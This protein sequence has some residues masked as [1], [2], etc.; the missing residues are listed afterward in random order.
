MP[1][2]TRALALAPLASLDRGDLLLH[3]ISLRQKDNTCGLLQTRRGDSIYLGHLI[4]AVPDMAVPPTEGQMLHSAH[5]YAFKLDPWRALSQYAWELSEALIEYDGT[6]REEVLIQEYRLWHRYYRAVLQ[7][8]LDKVTP[9][10]PAGHIWWCGAKDPMARPFCNIA[11]YTRVPVYRVLWAAM[12]KDE[13]IPPGNMRKS[14]LCSDDYSSDPELNRRMCV[15]PSHF[16]MSIRTEVRL[17]GF[18]QRGVEQDRY[19]CRWR[20]DDI[21]TYASHAVCPNNHVINPQKLQHWIDNGARMFTCEICSE[22]A[23][24]HKDHDGRIQP[25]TRSRHEPTLAEMDE[26]ARLLALG[27]PQRDH[28]AVD[29]GDS[30]EDIWALL[31]SNNTNPD[32]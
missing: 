24:K 6:E 11:G 21:T 32:V 31:S 7:P 23:R 16:E 3:S 27:P 25:R 18:R 26:Q 1:E 14:Q 8:V 30:D 20:I 5:C 22:W 17:N 13:P 2:P 10:D 9:P 29:S 4:P 28:H 12:K 19:R 15:N